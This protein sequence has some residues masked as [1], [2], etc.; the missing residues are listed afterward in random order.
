MNTLYQKIIESLTYNTDMLFDWTEPFYGDAL[1][2]DILPS[3]YEEVMD[4]TI[5]DVNDEIVVTINS[6]YKTGENDSDILKMYLSKDSIYLSGDYENIME[7]VKHGLHMQPKKSTD[8][9]TSPDG[10]YFYRYSIHKPHDISEVFKI[11]IHI[12]NHIEPH[13]THYRQYR[14]Y[15]W[16]SSFG[17]T[18]GAIGE[19]KM[20]IRENNLN[21]LTL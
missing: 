14:Q 10:S 9:I 4:H 11:I 18:D 8:N 2:I 3:N 20:A 21:N 16:K 1:D 7:Y 17:I 19:M 15:K 12:I 5:R 13:T 6:C